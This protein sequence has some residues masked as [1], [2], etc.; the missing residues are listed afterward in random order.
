[1]NSENSSWVGALQCKVVFLLRAMQPYLLLLAVGLLMLVLPALGLF[2]SGEPIPEGVIGLPRT[3]M[4]E[5][6]GLNQWVFFGMLGAVLLLIV[7]FYRQGL[8]G[9]LDVSARKTGPFPWWGWWG[10]FWSVAWWL[11]AWTRLPVFHVVQPYTFTPLWVGYIVVVNALRYQRA[12]ECMLTHRRV[13][14][15]HLLVASAGFWWFFEYLNRYVNNW[16][17]EGVPPTSVL[18]YVVSATPPFA[19]VLPAVLGTYEWLHIPLRS[20][21]HQTTRLRQTSKASTSAS[22]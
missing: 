2:V 7:P 19:T 11:I 6:P 16:Y 4:V 18:H 5:Q 20:G 9:R 17:Y 10:L 14:L 13:Y 12:R 21:E 3:V 8:R 1:M 15:L 22:H